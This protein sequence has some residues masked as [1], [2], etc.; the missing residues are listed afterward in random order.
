MPT[1]I[2]AFRLHDSDNPWPRLPRRAHVRRKLRNVV[3]ANGSQIPKEA[4]D[5]IGA[6]FEIERLLS[7]RHPIERCDARQQKARPLLATLALR[8]R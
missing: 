7:A 1:A 2:A 4:L 8:L 5:R 6:L 3:E